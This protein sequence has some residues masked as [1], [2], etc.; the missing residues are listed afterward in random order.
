MTVLN[1]PVSPLKGSAALRAFAADIKLSHSVFALP[2]ALLSATLAALSPQAK[3]GV[4]WSVGSFLLILVCM[5]CARTVAMAANR[6]LDAKLDTVNPRTARRAIPAGQLSRG[7]VLLTASL[8][9]VGF[10]VACAGFG[11]L[12]GNWWPIFLSVP[13]LAFL[14]CYPFLKRFTALC[15]YYLGAALALSPICAWIAITG[16]IAIEP[17]LMGAA[18]ICWTGG[19]D[20]IYA[21]VDVE[22]DLAHGVHS[23]PAKL[24]VAKALWVSRFTHVLS[25]ALLVALGMASADLGTI[26]YT[27][28]AV[29]AALL[30]VEHRL[31]R[32][33]DL[34]K[35][36]LAF[37][38]VNGII[39]VLL[40]LAGVVDAI[41]D[42]A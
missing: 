36:S 34:S 41:V 38:T 19:F 30:V 17:L 22:S 18:V 29:V 1:A 11:W 26:W 40:G 16:N 24:G 4:T 32:P 42:F 33:D 5:V 27:A 25:V 23:M 39:A 2:F 37:F 13:V 10:I 21:T 35:V 6:L 20:V 7:W 9:G 12:Y 8:F 15:H 14:C 28:V 3:W 31:V